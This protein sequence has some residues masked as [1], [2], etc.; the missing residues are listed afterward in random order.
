METIVERWERI[1]RNC[2][3][4]TNCERCSNLVY[5]ANIAKEEK[6]SRKNLSESK[7]H[8]KIVDYCTSHECKNCG[9]GTRKCERARLTYEFDVNELYERV[10]TTE[11][12]TEAEEYILKREEIGELFRQLSEKADELSKAATMRKEVAESN[13]TQEEMKRAKTRLC[14][15]MAEVIAVCDVL[16]NDTDAR[17]DLEHVRK[18]TKEMWVRNLQSEEES[19]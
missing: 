15:A 19:E 3:D 16:T 8:K 1:T 5:C 13:P 4:C 14:W 9:I 2:N 10:K 6:R 18:T 7:K 12:T 17:E 11:M